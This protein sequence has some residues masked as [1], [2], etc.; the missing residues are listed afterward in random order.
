MPELPEV[1]TV[2]NGLNKT[3]LNKTIKNIN[4][5]D[6]RPIKKYTPQNFTSFV[7]GKT[8]KNIIRFGKYI[9][10]KFKNGDSIV[11]HLRMTGKYIFLQNTK[12]IINTSHVRL[13]FYFT[14][15]SKLLFKDQRIFGTLTPY[16]A[17]ECI[18]EIEKNGL[19]PIL[20]KITPHYLFKKAKNRTIPVK[21]F[22]LDQSVIAGLGNIYATEALFYAK[23]NPQII[24]NKINKTQ[25]KILINKIVF[26]LNL[27]ISKNGT[28]ISDFKNID[29]KSGEFQNM[30]MVYGKNGQICKKC[31]ST[32][33][34]KIKQSGRSTFLCPHCQK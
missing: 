1:E 22:L 31:N 24:A 28:S 18:K 14:D 7:T 32:S 5:L 26:I 9:H 27:A 17:N 25:W 4:I 23:I 13:I 8:F 2:V 15:G 16:L 33:I 11:S 3:I 19:D 21:V 34:I 30:L 12:N 10:F 29:D 20:N 6:K